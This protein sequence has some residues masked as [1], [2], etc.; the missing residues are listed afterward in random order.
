[1]TTAARVACGIS[2][3]RG[4]RRSIVS[5]AAA[6]VTISANCVRAP[7]SRFTAVCEVPPPDGMAPSIAPHAFPSPVASNSRFGRRGGSP[8]LAKARPAATVSVKLISAMPTAPAQSSGQVRSPVGS[9]TGGP[10]ESGRP[11]PDRGACNPSRLTA[12]IP[13]AT[14][15]NGAGAFGIKCSNP[16]NIRIMTMPKI[17]VGT[18]VCGIE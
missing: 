10:G 11:I 17:S 9:K 12:A 3:M 1:M 4:A 5:S 16:I 8:L 7:A 13:A 14:T 6:A 2:P 15:I 18:E